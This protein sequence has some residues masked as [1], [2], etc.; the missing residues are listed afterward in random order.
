MKSGG[1]SERCPEPRWARRN[2][3]SG[4]ADTTGSGHS[5]LC[6]AKAAGAKVI[7]IF[8]ADRDCESARKLR[9][10]GLLLLKKWEECPG[11]FDGYSVLADIAK[12]GGADLV[13]H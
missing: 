13:P 2:R 4:T 12:D 10:S 7:K 9:D 8:A 3:K 5:A 6:A 1:A 11:D